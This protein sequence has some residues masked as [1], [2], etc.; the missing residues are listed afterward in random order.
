MP[1]SRRRFLRLLPA[2]LAV[3]GTGKTARAAEPMNPP[4]PRSDHFDGERFFNPSGKNPLGFRDL[5]KW[6]FSRAQGVWP[7]W[8]ENTAQPAL[9]ATLGPRECAVTFVGHASFLIQFD[10]LNILTD[11]IWSDRCSP[12]SWAGPK[13]VRA[14][15]IA[16]EAL[17]RIDLVLLSHNHYD[18]LDLPTLQRLHAAHRPLIVTTLGNKPFLADEGIDHVVELDWWQAHEP[19]PGVRVTATPAQHF[20][21]RGLGD[22]FKTLWGGFALETPA[23][24]LWFAGDS[25]YF[26]GFKTIGE[27]LG[28][29]D[30]AFIPIGAYEPR[31]F[32]QPVHCT[33]AEALQIHRD[34]RARRSLAMHFGCFPLADDSYEQ[35]VTDFQSAYASSGLSPGEFALPEVG[36]TRVLALG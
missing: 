4:Y 9:P 13:R 3:L 6:Q 27:K 16:F 26:D 18:H 21:A 29:F 20:A 36:E 1:F 30:L 19:R 35:P 5:M 11:P 32:M 15:G 7:T 31:W 2:G 33:P 17:P 28:P 14:P 24:K 10:G 12:V 22:R 34:V 23:G 8:V 25:G